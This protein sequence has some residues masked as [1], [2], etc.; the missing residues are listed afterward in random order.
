MTN[1]AASISVAWLTI[2][3]KQAKHDI[4]CVNEVEHLVLYLLDRDIGR[5]GGTRITANLN[6]TP[7]RLDLGRKPEPLR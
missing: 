7:D 3:G 4:R 5:R 6:S 2:K 1:G